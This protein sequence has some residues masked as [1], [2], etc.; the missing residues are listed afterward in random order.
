M[1]NYSFLAVLSIALVF[2]S[3][4]AAFII[5][6]SSSLISGLA[7]LTGAIALVHIQKTGLKGKLLAILAII[8]GLFGFFLLIPL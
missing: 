7:V 4:V 6:Y 5:P 3:A 8:A 1:K 2:F